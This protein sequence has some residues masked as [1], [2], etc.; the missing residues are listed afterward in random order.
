VTRYG[1]AAMAEKIAHVFPMAPANRPQPSCGPIT[2]KHYTVQELAKL[3]ELSEK[4]VR[5]L[6][7]DEPGV[8]R[9][10]G[11]SHNYTTLRIPESVARA[12]H[13]RLSR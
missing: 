2:E 9:I 12:V 13:R 1:S 4:T 6:F 10:S 8:L 11:Q 7:I 3:W 5:K